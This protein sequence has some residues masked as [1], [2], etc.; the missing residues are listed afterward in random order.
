MYNGEKIE[1]LRLL[2]E[3]S[4]SELAQKLE[5]SEQAIWQFENGEVSPKT[6]LKLKLAQ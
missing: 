3:M 6:S 2:F 1:E 5:V 4:R